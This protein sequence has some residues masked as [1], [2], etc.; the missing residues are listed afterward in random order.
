MSLNLSLNILAKKSEEKELIFS[1]T[2]SQY[3]VLLISLTLILFLV[4]F[5][6][7]YYF[8]SSIFLLQNSFLLKNGKD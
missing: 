8:Y 4:N 5:N 1:I 7:L 3:V 2:F 6:K